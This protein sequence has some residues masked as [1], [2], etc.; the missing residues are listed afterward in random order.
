MSNIGRSMLTGMLGTFYQDGI[1]ITHL[2]METET[3]CLSLP[4]YSFA[5]SDNS[6]RTNA[7]EYA[8]RIK[9]IFI[10]MKIFSPNCHVKY[11]ERDVYWTK[12]MGIKNYRDHMDELSEYLHSGY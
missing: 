7:M 2:D 11:I 12:E 5:Y 8:K 6:K 1:E 3:I 9:E 4:K 10:E